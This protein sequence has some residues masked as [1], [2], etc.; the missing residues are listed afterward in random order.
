MF[1]L[2][3]YEQGTPILAALLKASAAPQVLADNSPP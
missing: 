2:P 1:F 3:N